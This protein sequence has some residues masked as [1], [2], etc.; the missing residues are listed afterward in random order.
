MAPDNPYD[1]LNA[2]QR[3]LAD[4]FEQNADGADLRD[5]LHD[6]PID[7]ADKADLAQ[8][9]GG[10]QAAAEFRDDGDEF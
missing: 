10:R 1:H 4:H 8:A 7:A 6:A 9:W 3:N 2:R 5:L